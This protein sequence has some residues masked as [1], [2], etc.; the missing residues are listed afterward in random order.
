M[1]VYPGDYIRIDTIGKHRI[2]LS[3]QR[4]RIKQPFATP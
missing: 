1:K 2:R 3:R 4:T